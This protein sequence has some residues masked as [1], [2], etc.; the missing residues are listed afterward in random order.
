[1]YI[2]SD[3]PNPVLRKKVMIW[4]VYIRM[5]IVGKERPQDC[6]IIYDTEYAT[7]S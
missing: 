4:K 3:S 6:A 5:D 7:L 2:V 1:M